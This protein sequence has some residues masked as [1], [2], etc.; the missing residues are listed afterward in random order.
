MNFVYMR[1]VILMTTEIKIHISSLLLLAYFLSIHHFHL[2]YKSAFQKASKYIGE[3]VLSIRQGDLYFTVYLT[4]KL[5]HKSLYLVSHA[6]HWH[7]NINYCNII[8]SLL[9]I[10]NAGTISSNMFYVV[11]NHFSFL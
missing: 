4:A 5:A 11:R 8:A 7:H 10:A 1:R 3:N 9:Y 2:E 6:Y